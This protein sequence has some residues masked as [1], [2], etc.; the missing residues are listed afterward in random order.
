MVVP[1]TEPYSSSAF[2]N[3]LYRIYKALCEYIN[4]FPS[5]RLNMFFSNTVRTCMVQVVTS[6]YAT[7]SRTEKRGILAGLLIK[8]ALIVMVAQTTY[9]R[10]Q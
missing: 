9:N 8:I 7:E 5:P 10:P 2:G 6:K 1:I 3:G 4:A